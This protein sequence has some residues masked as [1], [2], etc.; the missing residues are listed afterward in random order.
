MEM[1]E[2]TAKPRTL[3]QLLA[4]D[5]SELEATDLVEMN[6]SVAREIPSLEKLDVL[7][8]C[9]VVDEWTEAFR[10]F[11]PGAEKKFHN[12]PWKWKHDL[13]FFRVG[14]L[15]GFLGH[16]YGIRYIPSHK[17]LAEVHYTNPGQLFLH[18]LIDTRLGTCGN[19]ATL[20][21]AICRRMGWPVSLACVKSH[22]ISRFD[23][24][25]VIHNIEVTQTDHPGTFSSDTDEWYMKK[26]GIPQKAIDCGSDLRCLAAREMMGA[27]LGQRGRYYTDLGDIERADVSFALSRA[28]F[29]KHRRAYIG[30]IIPMLL[31]GDRLFDAGE[32]GHPDSLFEDL[33]PVFARDEFQ[34][35]I[36]G[37][38]RGIH[39]FPVAMRRLPTI[40]SVFATLNF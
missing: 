2:T 29:H 24:G 8:Y 17:Y 9:R 22:F 32:V 36:N 31:H 16:E 12:S 20:H 13:H 18:G 39:T 5:D 15:A 6:L 37:M 34:K 10:K 23:N 4:A 33:A 38:G 14:M 27:F 21:V 30:A 3:W 25:Q 19:M 26:M 28:L 1:Q 40:N 35:T 11:L 7:R